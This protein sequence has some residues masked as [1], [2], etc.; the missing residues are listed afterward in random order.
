MAK[1]KLLKKEQEQ[2]KENSLDRG[3][4]ELLPALKLVVDGPSPQPL[5]SMAS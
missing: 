1:G 3:N 2:R 5:S 4:G